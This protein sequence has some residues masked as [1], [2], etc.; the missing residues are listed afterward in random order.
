MTKYTV[1]CAMESESTA[2]LAREGAEW[3]GT[4]NDDGDHARVSDPELI[5]L[6]EVAVERAFAARGQSS[7]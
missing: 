1:V 5:A 4:S 2:P 3:P 6:V 7:L